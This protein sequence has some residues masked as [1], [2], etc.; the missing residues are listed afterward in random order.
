MGKSILAQIP[1]DD[2]KA[3]AA[4]LLARGTPRAEVVDHLAA[5]VD[6]LVDWSKVVKGPAGFFLEASD[7]PLLKLVVGV[8]VGQVEHARASA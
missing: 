7:G 1:V 3:L 2:V 6:D 5:F 4:E 8:I